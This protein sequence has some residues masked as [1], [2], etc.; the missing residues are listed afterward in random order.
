M[1]IVTNIDNIKKTFANDIELIEYVRKIAIEN[2][3]FDYSI[4]GISDAIE[5]LEEYCPNLTLEEN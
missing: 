4:L 2:E 5:Y 1:Y 3:D